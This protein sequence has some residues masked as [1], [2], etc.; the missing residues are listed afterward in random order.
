MIRGQRTGLDRDE[1]RNAN[2]AVAGEQL[3]RGH[4]RVMPP[5]SL[6]KG[7]KRLLRGGETTLEGYDAVAVRAAIQTDTAN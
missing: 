7:A 1:S 2:S 5:S 6:E 4:W 3:Q